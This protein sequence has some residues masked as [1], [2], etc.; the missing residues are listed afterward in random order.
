[1]HRFRFTF[2]A[3]CLILIWLGWTDTDLHLR[4]RAPLPIDIA[5]VERHGPPREWLE[6]RGGFLNLDQA[7]STSGTLQ[8]DAL[9]VPLQT[10]PRVEGPIRLLVETRDERLLNHFRTYH[11]GLDSERAQ[12]E[13]RRMHQADF[14]RQQPVTGLVSSG[15]VARSNREKILQLAQMTGMDVAPDLIYLVEGRQPPQVRGYLFL[16]VGVLGLIKVLRRWRGTPTDSSPT[17]PTGT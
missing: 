9:L 4:N 6:V 16:A 14:L 5:E 1:M 17:V 7:I 2:L 11:F 15:L 3:V 13:Y 8:V 12:E 10:E